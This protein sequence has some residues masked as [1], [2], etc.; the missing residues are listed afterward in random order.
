M[1]FK[2]NYT[3]NMQ[4]LTHQPIDA[5]QFKLRYRFQQFSDIPIQ[6]LINR[7]KQHK[8]KF[9][10]KYLISV[11]ED[12]IWI[13]IG[14]DDRRLYSPHLHIE[15]SETNE[16]QTL[17]RCLYGPN[18]AMWTLFMFLHFVV[19]GIF[20][21]FGVMAYT[22]WQLNESIMPSVIV[23]CLMTVIWFFLYFFARMNRK[24]GLPQA[25]DIQ[26]VFEEIVK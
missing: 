17:L 10:P 18:P 7:F 25:E 8:D 9:Y 11:I 14:A 12:N 26:K 1:H 16:G 4:T 2:L 23:M 15:I 24:A 13:K 22:R 20:V 5:E 19:A 6:D 21:I 3:L